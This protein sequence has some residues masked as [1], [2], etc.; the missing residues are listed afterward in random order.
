M[1]PKQ[2]VQQLLES[3]PDG[4]SYQQINQCLRQHL[5]QFE[6]IR[7]QQEA[8]MQGASAGLEVERHLK[9]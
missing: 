9:Q 2:V 7:S 5:D 6:I 1:T 8:V 3:L 4:S